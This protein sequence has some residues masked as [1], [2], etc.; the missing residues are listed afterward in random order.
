MTIF[1]LTCVYPSFYYDRVDSP[2]YFLEFFSANSY[3]QI[4]FYY[5]SGQNIDYLCPK[6][7]RKLARELFLTGYIKCT[8]S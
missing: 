6:S 1:P 5:L 7:L 2:L 4:T 3:Y 8:Y